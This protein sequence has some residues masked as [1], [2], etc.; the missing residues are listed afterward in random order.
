MKIEFQERIDNYLKN[1]MSDEERMSFEADLANDEEL[2]EQLEFTKN[3]QRA[4]R[5]RNEKL[6]AVTEWKDDY[7]WEDNGDEPAT[8]NRPAGSGYDASP[9]ESN[10]PNYKQSSNRKTFYWISGIAAVFIVGLSLFHGLNV[11]LESSDNQSIP[12]DNTTYRSGND[13][14]EIGQLLSQKKYEEALIQIE[15]EIKALREDSTKICLD[16]SL[17]ERKKEYKL[18]EVKQSLN[19][20]YRKKVKALLG[21]GQKEKALLLLE[22]LN[23]NE[24]SFQIVSDSLNN[25]KISN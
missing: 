20:L 17:D 23:K 16:S 14:S 22:E 5:S 4:M 9:N 12:M 2:R 8:E 15:Q 13:N 7:S 11:S 21:L 25:S 24:E 19:D 18:L 3:V 1:K 6:A 10:T